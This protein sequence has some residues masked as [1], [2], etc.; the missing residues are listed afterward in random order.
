[1]QIASY[2]Q[3][4]DFGQ[5]SENGSCRLKLLLDEHHVCDEHPD[6]CRRLFAKSGEQTSQPMRFIKTAINFTD[7]L[8]DGEA[9][10]LCFR[11]SGQLGNTMY[12]YAAMYELAKYYNRELIID[13]IMARFFREAFIMNSTWFKEQRY[14]DRNTELPQNCSAKNRQHFHAISVKDYFQAP[15]NIYPNGY[16][17]NYNLFAHDWEEI[18]RLFT[19]RPEVLKTANELLYNITRKLPRH[20]S[21]TVIGIHVR[22]GDQA[23]RTDLAPLKYFVKAVRYCR[24]KYKFVHFIVATTDPEWVEKKLL[25]FGDV[26][27][28][29]QGSSPAVDMAAMTLCDHLIMSIGTYGFW[30]AW[31]GGGEIVYYDSDYHIKYLPAHWKNITC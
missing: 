4:H 23:L 25:P 18:S 21:V 9:A 2:V 24:H 22:R 31:L 17:E 15:P 30:A 20:K 14:Y 16:F 13:E 7:T 12:Q 26:S 8:K 5:G 3:T 11:K 6:R 1:M 19:F 10:P 28:L 27:A 29:P